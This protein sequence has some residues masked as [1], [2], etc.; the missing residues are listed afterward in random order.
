TD[1]SRVT[2]ATVATAISRLIAIPPADAGGKPDVGNLPTAIFR[3]QCLRPG[4]AGFG[5]P[6]LC[7][8]RRKR[9]RAGTDHAPVSPPD[10]LRYRWLAEAGG[11]VGTLCP[12]GVVVPVPELHAVATSATRAVAT[13]SACF[14]AAP[15]SLQASFHH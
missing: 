11:L 10:E 8:P 13:G 12:V 7:D 6:L 3:G 2:P 9:V 4:E 15:L 14:S 5:Q 1:P